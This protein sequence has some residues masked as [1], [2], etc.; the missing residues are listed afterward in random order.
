M[1]I[2]TAVPTHRRRGE[3]LSAPV[4][5]LHRPGN[6]RA[7]GAR[8]RLRDLVAAPSDRERGA[9]HAQAHQGARAL[10]ARIP[11]PRAVAGPDGR[12]LEPASSP[13]FGALHAGVLARPQARPHSQPR[14]PPRPGLRHGAGAA[15]GSQASARPLSPHARLGGALC[16]PPHRPA[17]DVLGP[18]QGHLDD[19]G[20]GEAREARRGQMG[21][22]L[23]RARA[24]RISTACAEPGPMFRSSITASILHG[25][26]RRPSAMPGRDGA[27]PADPVRIVSVGR[28]VAKKG[29]DDLLR[30]LAALPGDLHWRFAH[31][32]GGELL[33][34]LKA[35]AEKLGI[36]IAL[37]IPRRR[38]PSRTSSPAARGGSLR[39]A[40][41]G[42]RLGRPGRAS[43]T[44]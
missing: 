40:L 20:L 15:G 34:A 8:P 10:P 3:G 27:D 4:G 44:C 23:H 41:Q 5:N 30:A 22:D 6:P 33:G 1:A 39:P 13:G 26:R 12:R 16:G 11:L 28:A 17:L 37:R 14:T 36:G 43:R 7:R 38:R 42:C 9:S 2:A 24:P 32:G 25:F 31:V 21:R 35:H 18:C 29:F 19:A